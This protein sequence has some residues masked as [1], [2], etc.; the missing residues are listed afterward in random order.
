V[1]SAVDAGAKIE[2]GLEE[3]AA[4]QGQRQGQRQ[5]ERWDGVH[6][7]GSLLSKIERE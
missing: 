3:A 4:R 5:R 6:E 7:I 2:M 1:A